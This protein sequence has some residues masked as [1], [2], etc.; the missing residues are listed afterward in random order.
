MSNTPESTA[1]EPKSTLTLPPV[2]RGTLV[3]TREVGQSIHIGHNI[4]I[5]VQEVHRGKV[6]LCVMA[7]R[8][9]KVLRGELFNKS[10]EMKKVS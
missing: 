1:T 4:E 2:E 5:S 8:N 9:I 6:R 3:L 10:E 7:P